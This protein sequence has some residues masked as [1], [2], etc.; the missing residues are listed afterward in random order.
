VLVDRSVA[1]YHSARFERALSRAQDADSLLARSDD[2]R[3]QSL[4]ARAVFVAGSSLAA[5][6][7]MDRAKAAFA[8]VHALDPQF[9]PPKGWLSPRLEALYLAARSD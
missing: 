5:L 8:R 4:N 1:D 6:G 9:E 7:E 2:E 3:A